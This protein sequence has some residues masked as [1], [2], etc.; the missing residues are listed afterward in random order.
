[1]AMAATPMLLLIFSIK[2]TYAEGCNAWGG[3]GTVTLCT[4]VGEDLL[5]HGNCEELFVHEGCH[6][7][8]DASIYSVIV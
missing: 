3:G 1:M 4:G 8:L 5:A 6:I 7:S 2:G